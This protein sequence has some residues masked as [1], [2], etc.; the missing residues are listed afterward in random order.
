ML[1]L[2]LQDADG[3][4][5]LSFIC[6]ISDEKNRNL[7]CLLAVKKLL[8]LGANPDLEDKVRD[9]INSPICPSFSSTDSPV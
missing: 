3:I 2:F 5:P 9:S 6:R 8:E 4:T 1:I 7:D